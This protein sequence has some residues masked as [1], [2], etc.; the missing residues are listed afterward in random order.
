[1]ST[2][3]ITA[4]YE[5]QTKG[6]LARGCTRLGG[7]IHT[8]RTNPTGPRFLDAKATSVTSTGRLGIHHPVADQALP[9]VRAS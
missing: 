7:N 5:R 2:T 8:A 3:N 4:S 6:R 9:I 1:M